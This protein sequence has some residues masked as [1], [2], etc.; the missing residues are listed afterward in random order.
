[1]TYLLV[2]ALAPLTVLAQQ[3]PFGSP[4]DVKRGNGLFQTHCSYCHG[5]SGEGGRGA[6]LTTGQ[7][8]R[9]SSDAELFQT[10]RHGVPGSEMGPVRATDD[11]VWRMVAFVRSLGAVGVH[12]RASGDPAAGKVVYQTRGGCAAC[13]IVSGNGSNVGPELT[14]IGSRRGPRF[15]EESLVNP[16]ADLPVNYRAVRVVTRTGESV[17]GVR[18]NEDDISIQLRDMSDRL[19]SFLKDDL[20]EIRRDKPSLMPAYGSLLS[21][22]ELED[23]VAYLTTL[24][25]ER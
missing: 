2:F 3:N 24:R 11:D 25:G 18:L 12:E 20:K 6:D 4:D 9:G 23:L 22:K 19:R 15:L 16:E 1:M 8:R 17:T 7:F 14:D 13:H 10:V 5:A 21:R